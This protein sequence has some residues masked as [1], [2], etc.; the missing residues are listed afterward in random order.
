MD[1]RTK[2]HERPTPTTHELS[3]C[4]MNQLGLGDR[5]GVWLDVLWN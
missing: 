2:R 1:L 3:S 4:V 5:C